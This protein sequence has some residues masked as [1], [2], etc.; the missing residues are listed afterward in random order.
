MFH[1]SVPFRLLSTWILTSHSM[2]VVPWQLWCC[3]YKHIMSVDSSQLYP[4][5]WTCSKTSTDVNEANVRMDERITQMVIGE[6]INRNMINEKRAAVM[7]NED[8]PLIVTSDPDSEDSAL[9]LKGEVIIRE[10]SESPSLDHAPAPGRDTYYC[11]DLNH[12]SPKTP[13][14]EGVHIDLNFNFILLLI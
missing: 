14:W 4:G 5:E 3:Q 10:R 11:K 2:S 9:C 12:L 7:K 1:L 6:A 13:R 8:L